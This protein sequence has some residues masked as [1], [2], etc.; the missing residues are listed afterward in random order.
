MLASGVD[1]GDHG[2]Y[3]FFEA[4]DFP[5]EF[6]QHIPN[7]ESNSPNCAESREAKRNMPIAALNRTGSGGILRALCLVA[8]T[9]LPACRGYRSRPVG[10]DSARWAKS[11]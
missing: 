5:A 1:Q 11:V 4:L 10:D 9:G 3:G 8:F 2:H 7:K 6:V